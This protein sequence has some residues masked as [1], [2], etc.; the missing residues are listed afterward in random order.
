VSARAWGVSGVLG[1]GFDQT[2]P[3][4]GGLK[5]CARRDRPLTTQLTAS[6]PKPGPPESIS[7]DPTA[8][9]P[10]AAPPKPARSQPKQT[11]PNRLPP[12]QLPAWERAKPAE[13]AV[14]QTKPAP[15][16]PISRFLSRTPQHPP[17][18]TNPTQPNPTHPNPNP[19]PPSAGSCLRTPPLRG[20]AP[21][22]AS[23]SLGRAPT[24]SRSGG[25]EL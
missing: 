14:N 20:A 11:Q 24:R 25:W 5:P 3:S 13:P 12:G 15:T 6:P 18:P 4:P 7:S 1:V 9:D 19:N 8:Q 21:R 23:P 22:R 2:R 17:E 10:A 16:D